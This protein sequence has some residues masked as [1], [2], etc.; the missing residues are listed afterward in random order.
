M[1]DSA[2]PGGQRYYLLILLYLGCFGSLETGHAMSEAERLATAQ[3][4][5]DMFH[6]AY[7]NYMLYAFPHD[8]LKPLSKSY[9]DSLGELGNLEMEH[10]SLTYNGTALTLVDSL[11]SLAILGNATEFEKA[12]RWVGANLHFDWDVRVNVFEVNIR[13]L[14]GLISAHTLA[15]N[16][17][18]GLMRG[19][20]DGSLLWLAEDLGRRL[21]PAFD[22][23]TGIPYAWVNLKHG[24][25]EG[26]TGESSTA[27][28]G[29]L[30]LEFGMLSRLT[31]NPIFEDAA[32]LALRK[33]WSMRSPLNL[34]GTTLDVRSG[35]WLQHSSGIGA[36]VDSFYEYLA[37]AHFIFGG[38]EYWSMFQMAYAAVQQY[39]RAGPWYHEADIRTGRTTYRQFTS[40]QAFWPAL[41]VM[42]GDIASANETHRHFF[43]VWQKFGVFPE[44]YL[45]DHEMV[46]PTE[47]YYP[48]R[49]E[50]A[51]STWA[52]F[53][54][55][56][57]PWYREVG[58]EIAASLR[59]RTQVSGGFASVRDV[60]TG[61]LE[62]HQ[63]SFFLA[64]TLMYLYLLFD[65]SFLNGRNVVFS[66]EGHPLPV[67]GPA[68][69]IPDAL[70]NASTTAEAGSPLEG[71]QPSALM[72]QE[73]L[74]GR[75][76]C[77]N[78]R[79][80][81]IHGRSARRMPLSVCH[82]HDRKESHRCR[83]DRDCGVEA[84]SCRR[85]TC[86]PALWCG[87]WLGVVS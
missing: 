40:L 22:T 31:G 2:R 50:L 70:Q 61:E 44:R 46:H 68:P 72:A 35:Q 77:P 78:L 29:S 56:R 36:G 37:K 28:C 52:L 58:K 27:G 23:P 34:V 69:C 19:P 20:Y 42:V 55:T 54:A 64:E 43:G 4:V 63:H 81:A 8:E 21:L 73:S 33:L 86:S 48:L 83:S 13:V 62:D 11:S 6:H 25:R 82:V 53:Q 80:Q 41:Q 47:R 84:G 16:P 66:T 71:I 3:D 57:D 32:L 15:V 76:R 12:V 1:D 5:R 14:G 45:L 30:I 24:V 7:D 87:V 75:R 65:D 26:E 9:T 10:L 38:D 49:P 79:Y 67:V 85:R 18:S 60:I 39:Y 51:E 74:M 17:G 59:K